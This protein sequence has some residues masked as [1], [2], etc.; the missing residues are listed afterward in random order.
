M[1]PPIDRADITVSTPGAG[2]VEVSFYPAHA[3]ATGLSYQV[4]YAVKTADVGE[5]LGHC[6]ADRLQ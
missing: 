1:N 6:C 4:F 5:R 2:Q 3:G